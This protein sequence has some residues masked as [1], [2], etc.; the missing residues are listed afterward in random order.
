M[1]SENKRFPLSAAAIAGTLENIVT[2]PIEFVKTQLQLQVRS[3]ALYAGTAT[4]TSPLDVFVRTLRTSGIPGVYNG[5]AAF[6]L[7]APPRAVVR[8]STFE[9][10]RDTG[11]SQRLRQ[12][13]GG[14]RLSDLGCGVLAGV[15]D[16]A[17]CQTPMNAI[18]VKMVHDAAPKGPHQYRN[19]AHAVTQIWAQFGLYHG[20][21]SGIAPT[22]AK[23]SFC[24]GIRFVGYGELSQLLRSRDGRQGGPSAPVT[25]T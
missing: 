17:L 9:T 16:G 1:T 15:A 8:F 25:W 7:F 2:Y 13:P 3:S 23:V 6:F 10:L 11:P 14:K 18:Q 4:Y 22:V 21:F 24:A 12:T 19:L 20:F 5:G